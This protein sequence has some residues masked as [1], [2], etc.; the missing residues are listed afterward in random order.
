MRHISENSDVSENPDVSDNADVGE[1]PEMSGRFREGI[2]ANLWVYP[3]FS[4]P[5]RS[6]D[7]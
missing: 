3:H 1:N 2:P 5:V 4:T 7:A 6:P